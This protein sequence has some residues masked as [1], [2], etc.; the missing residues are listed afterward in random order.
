MIR[1][2]SILTVHDFI[3]RDFQY[4]PPEFPL[5]RGNSTFAPADSRYGEGNKDGNDLKIKP[6]RKQLFRANVK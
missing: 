1:F 4:T 6:D 5:N 3:I 2:A